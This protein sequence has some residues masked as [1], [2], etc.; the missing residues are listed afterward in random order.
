MFFL[1]IRSCSKVG[2]REVSVG[3]SFVYFYLS[4]FLSLLWR[5]YTAC[6]K[7]S[8]DEEGTDRNLGVVTC[9]NV[10]SVHVNESRGNMVQ[11]CFWAQRVG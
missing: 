3:W 6:T 9:V 7:A 1:L 11:L 4:V 5:K 10:E 8:F 2:G